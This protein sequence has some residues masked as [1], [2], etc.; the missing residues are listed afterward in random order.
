MSFGSVAEQAGSCRG[1]Q[2]GGHAGDF[3]PMFALA[4]PPPEFEY[5]P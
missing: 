5:V 2:L 1:A 3:E 4:D